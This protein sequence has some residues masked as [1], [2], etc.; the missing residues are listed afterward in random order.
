MRWTVLLRNAAMHDAHVAM[1]SDTLDIRA[2]AL[3]DELRHNFSLHKH[4][5][6]REDAW[7]QDLDCPCVRLFL[8]RA[9]ECTGGTKT[10]E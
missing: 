9:V 5:A 7:P 8:H 3:K 1:L 10:L 6:C 2:V 4:L